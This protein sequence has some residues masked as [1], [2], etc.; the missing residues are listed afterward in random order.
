[1]RQQALLSRVVVTFILTML[2]YWIEKRLVQEAWKFS[3]FCSAAF[4]AIMNNLCSIMNPPFGDQTLFQLFRWANVK[5]SMKPAFEVQA[6][7]FKETMKW[8]YVLVRALQCCGC[9]D[10]L[11]L[12]QAVYP[13]LLRLG[14]SPKKQLLLHG[15][16]RNDTYDTGEQQPT[17]VLRPWAIFL[18]SPNVSIKS[19]FSNSNLQT[20]T[21]PN[22]IF[23]CKS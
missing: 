2:V 14:Y 6:A 17:C 16:D 5:K 9:G 15:T 19:W 11:R 13:R 8:R 21:N 4:P 1:M 12:G 22:S 20:K 7:L 10:T 23:P 18:S 3:L